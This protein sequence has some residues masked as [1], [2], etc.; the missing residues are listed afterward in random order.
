[1]TTTLI[2]TS[3]TTT[4][5]NHPPRLHLSARL[6][7]NE[8]GAAASLVLATTAVVPRRPPSPAHLSCTTT[9]PA[10]TARP[11]LNGRGNRKVPR[12]YSHR[13]LQLNTRRPSS[14][15]PID[16]SSSTLILRAKSSSLMRHIVA[17]PRRRSLRHHH[18]HRKTTTKRTSHPHPS[19][20]LLACVLAHDELAPCTALQ[21]RPRSAAARLQPASSAGTE[22]STS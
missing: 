13:R 10:Q 21:L 18:P 11:V 2:F 16:P 6:E 14:T 3:R 4:M 1:M 15:G 9:F 19:P 5:P 17:K 20:S 12:G 22:G 7:G 8:A